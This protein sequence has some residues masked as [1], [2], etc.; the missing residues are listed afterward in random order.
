MGRVVIHDDV[1]I[2]VRRNRG[3]DLL[4]KVQELGRTVPFVALAND[5]AGGDVERCKQRGRAV[6][7]IA[8]CPPEGARSGRFRQSQARQQL[9]ARGL[10][11]RAHH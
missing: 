7:D 3:V 9:G 5:E 8:M 10:D 6:P 4:K 11:G 1:N 2:K